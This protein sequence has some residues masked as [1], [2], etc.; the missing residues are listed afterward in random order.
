V[1]LWSRN[2]R[3]R[4]QLETARS[5][6]ATS[7]IELPGS[8]E[9]TGELGRALEAQAVVLAVQPDHVR[10]LL[11]A[12]SEHFRPEQRVVHAVK[13]FE[14]GGMPVSHVIEQETCVIQTGA[15]GGPVVPAELWRGEECGA[16]VGSRFQAVID[17]VTALLSGPHVRVY[18]SRDLVGVEVGG[19]MRTP[20]A[21]AAG[22]LQGAG[23]GR[24]LHAVLL[25]RGIA[26]GARLAE[27]LGG[28][29]RTLA[30]LS[31]I[32]DWMLTTTDPKDPLVKGGVDLVKGKPWKQAEGASRV[33]TLLGLAEER[34][35]DMPI[36][37]A[38][39]AILD[40]QPIKQAMS[41][42]MSRAAR[43]ELD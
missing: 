10:E 17:E 37:S 6:P 7:A 34:G 8:V 2:P 39:G 27:S 28:D 20:M 31:G 19:A 22:L 3:K 32:G 21:I 38:V 41:E 14:R 40:G 43:S 11:A 30:G 26:E 18:G 36:T 5:T 29:R 25:T 42:L 13:G 4:K 1:R 16:V 15:V 23:M 12:A 33:A 9:I 24:A 35:V